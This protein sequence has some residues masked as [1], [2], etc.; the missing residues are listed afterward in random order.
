MIWATIFQWIIVALLGIWVVTLRCLNNRTKRIEEL[1]VALAEAKSRMAPAIR[2]SQDR[3]DFAQ[4]NP[5]SPEP[6]CFL[7]LADLRRQLAEAQREIGI[8]NQNIAALT[9]GL[10]TERRTNASLRGQITKIKKAVQS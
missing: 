5:V 1:E 6:D 7:E 9:E 4:D 10:A 8:D 3:F 2:A